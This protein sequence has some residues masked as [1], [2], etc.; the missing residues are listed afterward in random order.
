M[1]S[2][3]MGISQ[4]PGQLRIRLVTGLQNS[5]MAVCLVVTRT[6]RVMAMMRSA[7]H[8]E[9]CQLQ[10]GAVVLTVQMP[11]Q[12]P[13]QCH[14]IIHFFEARS[15]PLVVFLEHDQDRRGLLL[16][17]RALGTDGRTWWLITVHAGY[18]ALVSRR[19]GFLVLEVVRS[20]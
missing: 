8:S 6:E 15:C 11:A 5:T 19:L 16:V 17:F 10:S 4:P 14:F 3:A 9:I 1:I 12:R 18:N 20:W 7:Y 13:P 2:K